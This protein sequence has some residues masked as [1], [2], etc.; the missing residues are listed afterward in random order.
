MTLI[1]LKF[2]KIIWFNSRWLHNP[3][4]GMAFCGFLFWCHQWQRSPYCWWK[5]YALF[6]IQ[7]SNYKEII[8]QAKSFTSNDS[9]LYDG[10][11]DTHRLTVGG[12]RM[13]D[14]DWNFEGA[15]S[16]L[17]VNEEIILRLRDC[18]TSKIICRSSTL[19][20]MRPSWSWSRTAAILPPTNRREALTGSAQTTTSTMMACATK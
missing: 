12:E 4:W 16:C 8:Q 5:G 15:I 20:W 6:F 17:Q 3:Y 18:K 2:H 9:L 7:N 10:G 19:L 13:H 14:Q 1:S 11:E